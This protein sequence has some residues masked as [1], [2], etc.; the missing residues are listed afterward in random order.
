MQSA[1]NVRVTSNIIAH[2][3][4][5]RHVS[6]ADLIHAEAPISL[7]KHSKLHPKDKIIWDQS[8]AEE[9]NGLVVLYTWEEITEEELRYLQKHKDAKLLPTMTVSIIKKDKD[10]NPTRAK[11]RIVALGNLDPYA[12][13]K[14]DC[15][16][17]VLAQHDL[18]L[19]INLAVHLNCIPKSGDVSQA[20]CQS[21]L[22][23]NE[24]YVCRPPP[25]CLYNGNNKYW[26]LLKTLYGLK[27]SPRHWYNRVHT[28]LTEI[29][30]TRSPNSPCVY[31][32]T[33]IPGQ[34]PLYLG[35]Y[36]DDFIFFSQSPEVEQHFETQFATHVT[37]V[38]YN[39]QVDFFLGI[40]FDCFRHPDNTVTIHLSQQAFIEN[41]LITQ[42]MH[43]DNIN[44]VQSPYR[45]GY[46]IDS[47]PNEAYNK[48]TQK[49]YTKQLQSIAGSLT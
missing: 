34:P 48:L 30:L 32:G 38:T 5:A 18:R 25:G 49:Q 28:I 39:A 35:L 7:L 14:Q 22:P 6:A 42:N 46:P 20:F 17:P 33:L 26:K 15:F 45:S 21:F 47:I 10:G 16:A 43:H 44:S 12:W 24:L 13:D 11:Y 3:I 31:S 41:L 4:I 36:V 9:Y 27:R 8:Y 23:E 19:L 29:G 2:H 1:Q 40:K 37:K